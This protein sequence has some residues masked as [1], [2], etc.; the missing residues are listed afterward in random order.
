M[1]MVL[2]GDANSQ[3]KTVNGRIT[4]TAAKN[5]LTDKLIIKHLNLNI[6]VLNIVYF[7]EGKQ[8]HLRPQYNQ[9]E[10]VYG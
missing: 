8:K 2:V 1:N 4:V 10:P 6:V 7:C 3:Y 5:E 9:M